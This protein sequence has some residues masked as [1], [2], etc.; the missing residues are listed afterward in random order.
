[1]SMIR[2]AIDDFQTAIGVNGACGAQCIFN[3]FAAKIEELPGLAIKFIGVVEQ[4]QDYVGPN[5][6]KTIPSDKMRRI[7]EGI[8]SITYGAYDDIE[9]MYTLVYDTVKV[10]LP[11]LAHNI[12]STAQ[13]IVDAVAAIPDC[14]IAATF[15]LMNAKVDLEDDVALL[16]VLRSQY[17]AAFFIDTGELPAWL[18]PSQEVI[19]ILSELADY[20]LFHFSVLAWGCTD[21]PPANPYACQ[22]NRSVYDQEVAE[23]EQLAALKAVGPIFNFI[24]SDIIPAF[25]AV[26]E[27]Y[28]EVTATWDKLK[29]A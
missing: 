22:V 23:G 19:L 24:Q 14:P 16:L 5:A 1:M 15:A 26:T 7:F 8:Y 4:L 3:N 27:L 10:T 12:T 6:T 29:Q 18:D 11:D 21:T 20:I 17:E 2:T 28:S 9:T 13:L 25:D